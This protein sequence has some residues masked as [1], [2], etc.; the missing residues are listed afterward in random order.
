VFDLP[1]ARELGI[2]DFLIRNRDR[3]ELN[4]K[5]GSDGQVKPLDHGMTFFTPEGADR[6][7]PRSPFSMFWAGHEEA[8]PSARA[9]FGVDPGLRAKP[10]TKV[11]REGDLKPRVS[12]AY[13]AEVRA[14]LE[15]GKAEFSDS[16]WDA[17]MLRL[18]MLVAAA[19]ATIDGESPME[20]MT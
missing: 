6:D 8:K 18:D 10:S 7:V 13:L 1:G 5:V 2:M 11:I 17:I 19:P 14:R 12:K 3:H 16:E 9:G 20:A 15:L 4:W